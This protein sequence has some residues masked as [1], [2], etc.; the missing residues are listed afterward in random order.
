MGASNCLFCQIIAK[1]M[2]AKIRY[3]DAQFVAFD[4]IAPKAPTHILIVPRKHIPTVDDIEASDE[5]LVGALIYAAKQIAREAG[6]ATNG[7][8][9]VFNVRS[10]GGQVIDHI[11]LHILGGKSL[12]G[13]A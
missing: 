5:C 3:E 12:G 7:Y 6:L 8:R 4:D 10:H 11:H 9:L 1:E 2:P 13:M